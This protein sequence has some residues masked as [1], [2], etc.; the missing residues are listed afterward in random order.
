MFTNSILWNYSFNVC[1][2]ETCFEEFHVE[3]IEETAINIWLDT[4]PHSPTDEQPCNI[5][6]D[7]TT[8]VV[9]N[10]VDVTLDSIFWALYFNGSNCLEGAGVERILIDLQG[11]QHLMAS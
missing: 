2:L 3:T 11:N 10:S 8:L 6:D 5:V 9:I 7:R 1:A 4:P